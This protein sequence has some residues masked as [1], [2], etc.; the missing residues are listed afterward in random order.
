MR[1]IL[2]NNTSKE[3]SL[4]DTKLVLGLEI[5]QSFGGG[6]IAYVDETG[7]HGLMV[8]ETD[9]INP[10]TFGCLGTLIGVTGASNALYGSGYNNTLTIRSICDNPT[11][12]VNIRYAATACNQQT[13]GGFTD[14]FLPSIDEL[15]ILYNNR[16]LI[17]GFSTYWYSSSTEID[18]NNSKSLRFYDNSIAIIPKNQQINVRACRYF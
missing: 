17:G 4:F 14:W 2:F 16:A 18:A 9:L 6:K 8:M 7:Q 12:S 3:I 13:I 5:G 11:A 15:Q 10:R 1:N